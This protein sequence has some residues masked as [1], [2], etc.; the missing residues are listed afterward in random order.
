[1]I[2]WKDYNLEFVELEKRVIQK[3]SR[4]PVVENG[5]LIDDQKRRDFTINSL[6]ISL[7]KKTTMEN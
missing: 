3:N 1:M 2:S 7:N 6:S 4:N 5:S